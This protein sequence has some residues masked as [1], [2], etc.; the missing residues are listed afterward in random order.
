MLEDQ[1]QDVKGAIDTYNSILEMAGEE[2]AALRALDRLYESQEEWASLGDVLERQLALA[3]EDESAIELKYRLGKVRQEHLEDLAGAIE[4]Y[5]EILIVDPEHEAARVALEELLEQDQPM[6]ADVAEI[7]DPI[8]QAQEEWN[9]LIGVLEILVEHA[10]EAEDKVSLLM[11]IGSLQQQDLQ[12]FE[13]AFDAFS[14][15]VRADPASN[16]ARAR[17]EELATV[18]DWWPQLAELLEWAAQQVEDEA[19]AR[20]LWLLVARVRWEQMENAEAAVA[21]YQQVLEIDPQ[22][23]GAVEALEGIFTHTE[24]WAD[25]IDVLR[26]KVEMTFEMDAKE[27]LYTQMASIY[28]EMLD[29]PE[30]A[31]TCFREILALDPENAQALQA[32]DALYQRQGHWTDLADNLEQQLALAEDEQTEAQL[33]LRL[34]DLRETKME[35]VESAI[36]IH[37]DVLERDLTNEEALAALERLLQIEDHRLTIAQILEPIYT[38]TGEWE[39]LIGVTEIMIAEADDPRRRVELRHRVAELY[40][41]MGDDSQNAFESFASALAEEPGDPLTQENLE[42]LASNLGTFE[43]LA[44][45]FDAQATATEE[46]PDLSSALHAK[47]ATIA[48]EQL[49][50]ADRAI[51]H[52]RKVLVLDPGNVTAAD[53]LVQIYQV[54]ERYEDLA[55]VL[56]D[57]VEMIDDLDDRK[58]HLFRAGEIYESVLEQHE[59]AVETYNRVLDIDIDDLEALGRLEALYLRMEQWNDLQGIYQRKAD[60][61]DTVEEKKELLYVMGAVYE[62]EVQDVPRAIDT[63]QRV[64]ELDPDDMQ[65][66]QRL[67]ALYLASEQWHEL[68]S[69]LEREAELVT[70]PDEV[71]GFKFRIGALWEQHLDDIARAVDVYREILQVVP[72]HPETI[73]ALEGIV[74]GDQEPLLAAEI[75]ERLYEDSG[76]WRKLIDVLEVQ[77]AHSDPD[78]PWSRVQLLHRIAALFES[79]LHLDS[80]TE[81]FDAYARAF[82]EDPSNEETLVALDRLAE[83]T[84]RWLELAQ[85]YDTFLEDADDPDRI[86]D[87][88]LRVA[89]IHEERLGNAEIA[90][91]RLVKVAD[92]DP[93]NR[94]ALESLD[95]LYQMTEKWEALSEVLRRESA[96]AAS[97]EDA[98]EYQ[99]RLGQVYEQELQNVDEA[100]DCYRD[101]LAA[102]PEHV[103]TLQALEMLFTEGTK[104]TEIAEILDPL[105]RMA[106]QWDKLVG[107]NEALLEGIEDEFERVALMHRIA[108]IYEEKLVDEVNAFTW[109]GHAVRQSPNDDRSLED[110][111]RLAAATGGWPDAI[112]V[113]NDVFEQYEDPEIKKHAALRMARASEE[114]LGDADNAEQTYRK[115]L[116]I[117]GYDPVALEALD[118]IYLNYVEWDKLAEVL[119]RRIEVAEVDDDRVDRCFRLGKVHEDQREDDD[120][121]VKCFRR[122]INDFDPHHTESL[123][124]LE[125][126]FFRRTEWSE[127]YEI[128]ERKL[129]VAPGDSTRADLYA[130]M[131]VTAAEAMDQIDKGIELWG[132]VLDIRGEDPE[133]L[134][135]LG[136]LYTVQENWHELV[137]VLDRQA[138]IA[139]D[140]ETRIR[141][142][143]ELGVV[144]GEKLEDDQNALENWERVLDIAPSNL[145]ALRALVTIHQQNESWH[146]LVDTLHRQIDAGALDMEDAE[147][148]SCYSR[149]GHLYA[150]TL[151]QPYDA[152][153]SWVKVTEIDPSDMEAIEALE[154]LYTKEERWEEYVA[155]LDRK[156]ELIDDSEQKIEILMQVASTW[157]E[158]LLEPNKGLS[159]FERILEVDPLHEHAFEQVERIYDEEMRWEDLTNLYL[160][161]IGNVSDTA[162]RID[163]YLRMARVYE[164]NLKSPENAFLILQKAFEEDYTH[165]ET[166]KEIERL[167]GITGK[168]NELLNSC[169]QVVQTIQDRGV[170]ISLLVKIGRWYAELDHPDYAV[171]Y[172]NQVLQ[173]DSEHTGALGAMADIYR[174]KGQWEALA[175]VLTRQSEV[176]KDDEEKKQTYYSLGELYEEKLNNQQAALSSYNAA[177]AIDELMPEALVAVERL[178]RN[179]QA[180]KELIPVLEK[181]KQIQE[182]LDE[183]VEIQRQIG[184]IYEHRIEDAA[185]AIEAYREIL[186][187]DP[188][189]MPALKGL[190]GLFTRG[191]R[192]QDL[193]DILEMQLEVVTT[194]RE[195]IELLLRM[196]SMLENEFV[197]PERAAE[198]LETVLETDPSNESALSGLERLYRQGQKWQDLVDTYFRHIEAT[199]DRDV[200]VNLYHDVA[201]VYAAELKDTH[202]AIEALQNVLSIEEKNEKALERLAAH[203]EQIEDWSGAYDALSRLVEI[204]L[205]PEKR[206]ELHYRLG[207]L[208]AEQMFDQDGAVDRY[209]SALDLEPGH[210]PS[211]SALRIIYTERQDWVA[212]ARVLEQEQ[213]FTEK[214]RQRSAL[215]YELGRINDEYLDDHPRAIE[216]YELALEC[217]AENIE[218]AKPLVEVYVE[219]ERWEDA[220]RLLDMLVRK[221]PAYKPEPPQLQR[222]QFLLG[223]ATAKLEKDDK[224]LKAYRA[225]YDIDATHLPTLRGIAAIYFK[226]KDWEK[227]FKFYQMILVHHKESQTPEQIV[228]IFYRLGVIKLEVGERRKSLNMFDKALEIDENHRPTLEAVIGLHEK[229]GD[230]EKVIHFKKQVILTAD[231]AERFDL[232]IQVGD[233]WQEK[234]KNSQKAIQ[235]Y[236]EALELQ[237]DN[238]VLLHKLLNLYT[239]TEQW[240]QAVEVIERIANLEKNE[241]RIAKYHYSIALVYRDKI[242]DADQSIVHFNKALD[243]DIEQLKAFEAID[244]IL[245]QRKDWQALEKN[246]RNMLHRISGKGKDDVEINL[247]HFLGEIYRTRMGK[248][249]AAAE[250]FKMASRLDPNN[251]ERHTILA[252]L[253]MSIP[254]MWENA[255]E[256]HQFLI[257]ENPYRVDSYKALRK[258]YSDSR[259]YD[260]AWCLCATLSFLK[261]ADEEET[262]F[263]EQYRTKGMIRAQARLDNERWIKDLFHPDEDL[264]IGKI[265]ETILPSVRRF[266]VQPHK[267]FGLRKKDKHDPMTSTIAFAKTFAYVAQVLALPFMPELY[268]RPDQAMGLQ[269]ATTEPPASV[270]G[271]LLLSGFTPQDLTFEIGRHLSYYRGEHYIR[272]IEPTTAGMRLLL[273]AGIK[274]VN[275]GFQTPPDP[276]GVLDQTVATLNNSLTPT[277]REQLTALVRKFIQGSEGHVDVK[278]WINAVEMTACRAG[279]LLC[280]DIQSA[281]RMINNQATTVGDIPAKEKIKE[282]VLFSVSEQYFRLRQALGV[283]IGQ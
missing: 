24:R 168:W 79:D 93:E 28:D 43:R 80:A 3:F 139:E 26:R 40:E 128:F 197:K 238:H 276:S 266:K 249:E 219:Q 191:E 101:I 193:L 262:Q 181:R 206:V 70:N 138:Q 196:A 135:A 110:L 229:Q 94:V 21:A 124:S 195:R 7:L 90:I 58:Q 130:K 190:E 86:V 183:A 261:K 92:H 153:E 166:A 8:Y 129:D 51:S 235:N 142:Y 87:I 41:T 253:Y 53:A 35:Q 16:D 213:E 259:Q 228:D 274:S 175:Q 10:E 186:N 268:L 267:A 278:R 199:P 109:Y 85:L 39:K 1:I 118:R 257:R 177:L 263:F 102:A 180:W 104:Q 121:A 149:L 99:F 154:D 231:D 242:K 256:E 29:D 140:D 68:L 279:F 250:A 167:A 283:T 159:A 232:L 215:L 224:S 251:H 82:V 49:G 31:S 236:N 33:K 189:F 116:D 157:D 38:T 107:I 136:I 17:L 252:E 222:F 84:G 67:D 89:R 108:E 60:L 13:A 187:Q 25:L 184:E 254:E 9:K 201:Q 20:E 173:L 112:T 148:K 125:S 163:L 45:V 207:K 32:L 123:D 127:L 164:K 71:I 141:I 210:L 273:L 205:E 200:R 59:K 264:Y 223:E 216:C 131:A 30:E 281:A 115:V 275:P 65:A 106:G 162:L 91:E 248:F 66:M 143:Q 103:S 174:G 217:D 95:R 56:I 225:A 272:W 98:L 246:Y 227:A 37:R 146:D 161:R 172:F 6:R 239:S 111:E 244:R 11:R 209:Q 255:V 64:L 122:I 54:T 19:L 78:D 42:R 277:A 203:Y 18:L 230:W 152:I 57:K 117:D 245:T 194:E 134:Q 137:E 5:R 36:E 61:V 62:R 265:Y 271:Q 52:W 198:K 48:E 220:E 96:I 144:W 15:A 165:D 178:Y 241:Q 147:I 100:I 113:Y 192:W 155:N 247:W 47:V 282:L 188:T 211:L 50:D 46:D 179:T 63:Y 221:A 55:Q 280:N 160:A 4:C 170:Q 81:A 119:A 14:R 237:P 150:E 132:N 145:T 234:L 120:E 169:N 83:A 151:E 12:N 27:A 2:E 156:A 218:A 202:S 270:V 158:K 88:G 22:D 73:T 44:E 204:V 214:D 233:L 171:A 269:Y 185:S 260:K 23:M 75:L 76:E 243:R 69:I 126:I 226:K 240:Q 97:P 212:A 133:A 74:R 182:D 34:A 72:D 77:L 258:I 176:S 105:Y 114:E 208:L